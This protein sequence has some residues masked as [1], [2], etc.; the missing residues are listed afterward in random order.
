MDWIKI[1]NTRDEAAAALN[2]NP[3]LLIVRGKRICLA[4]FGE[5]LF[6]VQDK[7]THNGES[8]SKG[9]LNYCGEIVC[10]L[11]HYQFDLKTGRESTQRSNDLECFPIQENKD[12]I[13]IGV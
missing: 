2:H 6:A 13:F 11:H 4:L 8:L 10:P 12:G 9:T 7:C 5:K 1:F 3:R